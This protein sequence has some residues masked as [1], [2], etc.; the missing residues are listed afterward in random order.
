MNISKFIY[1]KKLNKWDNGVTKIK[2]TTAVIII[3]L[4]VLITIG[5]MILNFSEFL[6]GGYAT[7]NNVIVTFTYL[8]IWVSISII[9]VTV[10]ARV[11]IKYC[12]VFWAINLILGIAFCANEI[13]IP[14]GWAL[15][16][17]VL[18]GGQWYGITYFYGS[19]M[20]FSIIVMLISL[21]MFTITYLSLRATKQDKV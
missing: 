14:V 15:P 13:E 5:S 12:S 9:G 20:T 3:I 6:M 10:K 16:L 11:I 4:S 18:F 17:S 21:V 8:I 19:I 1:I 2:N 7:L